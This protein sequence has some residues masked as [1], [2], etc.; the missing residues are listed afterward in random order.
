VHSF[1]KLVTKI[2]A[3][4]LAKRL[5]GMVSPI[6]SAFTQGRFI[7]DNF[8]LVQQTSRLLH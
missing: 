1:A 2:L 3:N 7:Q 6:Q 8:M 4:R 5:D